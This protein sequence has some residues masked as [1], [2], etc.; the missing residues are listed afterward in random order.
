MWWGKPLLL[1]T[2]GVYAYWLLGLA[3][4]V[5]VNRHLLLQDTPPLTGLVL[6]AAGVLTIAQA[7]PAIVRR[8]SIRTVPA[9]LPALGLCLLVI[10]TAVTAWQAWMPG[11]PASPTGLYQPPVNSQRNDTTAAFTT[12]LPGG[13]YPH[14]TPASI[15]NPWFPTDPIQ[16]DVASVLGA[17]AAPVTLSAS[18]Q[19]FAYVNWPGYIGVTWGAAGI[20]TDWPARYAALREAFPRHRPGRVRRRLRAHRVRA[21]RRVHSPAHRPG[22][23]DLAARWLPGPRD[24]FHARPVQP[25]RLHRLHRPAGQLRAGRPAATAKRIATATG[26][27]NQVL[28][29]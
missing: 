28:F 17:S 7:A 13:S 4:F 14:A 22:P 26:A 23:L 12:A 2:V 1:L 25:G 5:L 9:G 27:G 8:L 29:A 11:G 6:A 16:K 20:D 24:H 10:W 15:R 3:S 21:H 19:P 18:E